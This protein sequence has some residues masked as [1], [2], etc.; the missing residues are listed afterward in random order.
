MVAYIWDDFSC[1][2]F[3][4]GWEN[5]GA[6]GSTASNK[7]WGDFLDARQHSPNSDTWDATGFSYDGKSTTPQYVWFG[8][9]R[10][11]P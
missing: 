11:K 9:E 8:R 2:P 3:S 4:C 6:V 1:D 10:D 5:Y 7:N